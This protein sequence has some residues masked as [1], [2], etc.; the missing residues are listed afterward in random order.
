M[1][2]TDNEEANQ[3]LMG[4]KG[5]APEDSMAYGALFD[6]G[7][8]DLG[9]RWKGVL[10]GA[11]IVLLFMTLA[12]LSYYFG[13]WASEFGDDSFFRSFLTEICAGIGMFLLAPL[14]LKLGRKYRGKLVFFTIS[15]SV[16]CSFCAYYQTGLAQSLL[17]EVAVGLLLLTGLE[18]YFNAVL[19]ATMKKLRKIGKE[20]EELKRIQDEIENADPGNMPGHGLPERSAEEEQRYLDALNQGDN[21]A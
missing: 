9:L 13:V 8:S 21:K 4:I 5:I 14:L 10:I 15:V 6:Y 16:I 20:R 2:I 3:Y 1:D 18:I 12:L 7:F 11:G 17:I 19:D